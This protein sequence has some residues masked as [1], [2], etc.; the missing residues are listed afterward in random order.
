MAESVVKL[1]V[2]GTVRGA[3][4]VLA[5]GLALT[6]CSPSPTSPAAGVAQ[7]QPVARSSAPGGQSAAAPPATTGADA[8][9]TA[10]KQ[11]QNA[12]GT[13]CGGF[14][15]TAEYKLVVKGG[16]SCDDGTRIMTAYLKQ[17]AA[18]NRDGVHVKVDGFDGWSC[19][20]DQDPTATVTHLN[21]FSCMR[22]DDVVQLLP[23]TAG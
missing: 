19:I 12:A 10:Q 15:G 11:Q 23:G 9:P 14:L 2:A 18:N 17:G 6:G 16:I 1:G 22:G 8:S 20:F 7:G 13:D 21:G 3:A 5:G 4:V